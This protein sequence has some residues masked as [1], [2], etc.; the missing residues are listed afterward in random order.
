MKIIT[1]VLAGTLLGS[2]VPCIAQS[3]DAELA[4]KLSNPVA[5]LISVPFQSNY[6]SG[7]G[8]SG[9][10]W[11]YKL[12]FQPV[13]PVSLN[14]DWN[15]IIRTIIPYIH[16]EDVYKGSVPSFEQVLAEVPFDLTSAQTKELRKAYDK[17]IASREP[18]RVQEGL[19]DTTQSF[20]FSPKEPGPG[21][22]IWGLGPVFLYPTATEELLGTEKWGAG[23]TGLLLKQTNGWT[24]GVLAN[25]LW[26]FA[27]E[28]DRRS[29]NSTFLQ[30]FLSYQTKTKTTFGVNTEAS[31][32]WNNSQWTVPL[33]ASVSQLVRIGKLPVSFQLGGRYYADGPSGGPEWGLRFAVTFLFPTSRPPAPADSSGLGK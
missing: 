28:E 24:M 33:N 31:Y 29:I 8:P 25:H 30:P 16:Q 6:D 26:S 18:D 19:S 3:D 5:S 10:G 21:G 27:G 11:Q 7:M 15:L 22:I 12:N 14:K 4:K 9:D 2:I 32:D 13:V 1:L 20:F 17:N 23:P